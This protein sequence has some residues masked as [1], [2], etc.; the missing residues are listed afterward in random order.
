MFYA[1][2]YKKPS[3]NDEGRKIIKMMQEWKSKHSTPYRASIIQGLLE[4]CQQCPCPPHPE[5]DGGSQSN[6][7]LP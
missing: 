6:S 4:E 1:F 7:L 5:E 3:N 2:R